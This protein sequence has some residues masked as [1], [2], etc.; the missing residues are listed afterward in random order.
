MVE[1]HPL[2]QDEESV[3]LTATETPAPQNVAID[4]AP[5]PV[6]ITH[7]HTAA[8]A[9]PTYRIDI[10]P[11]NP[12]TIFEWEI[13]ID[14]PFAFDFFRMLRSIFRLP[15]RRPTKIMP[16]GR[17]LE[18]SR[19]RYFLHV[20]LYNL[21][22]LTLILGMIPFTTLAFSYIA[23]LPFVGMRFLGVMMGTQAATVLAAIGLL[24]SL[25][26][27]VA[28]I[29]QWFKP[30]WTRESYKKS[31]VELYNIGIAAGLFLAG[32]ILDPGIDRANVP[33]TGSDLDACRAVATR[34]VAEDVVGLRQDR[35]G[36][37]QQGGRRD[38]KP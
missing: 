15:A 14:A 36:Q 1:E 3:E 23:T 20:I 11:S 35:R 6:A 17:T 37:R 4:H 30:G 33:A 12:H 7:P 26:I 2:S 31:K 16:D 29:L 38:E 28:V 24:L 19:R 18:I 10:P 32:G 22:R 9:E 34:P 25:M 27:P 13:L 8:T 5:S 21:G